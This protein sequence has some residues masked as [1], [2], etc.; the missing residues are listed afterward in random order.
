MKPT[1]SIE[2]MPCPP[3]YQPGDSV[4]GFLEI[5]GREFDKLPRIN[6]K[7]TG[8][9]TEYMYETMIPGLIYTVLGKVTLGNARQVNGYCPGQLTRTVRMYAVA[10]ALQVF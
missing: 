7:F 4:R 9:Y 1:V 8:A 3:T 5:Q 10:A 2:S 6:I